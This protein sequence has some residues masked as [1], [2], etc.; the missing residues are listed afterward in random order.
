[1]TTP[2]RTPAGLTDPRSEDAGADTGGVCA[3]VAW[4]SRTNTDTA[5]RHDHQQ[6]HAG[7]DI[8][9]GRQPTPTVTTSALIAFNVER[10]S[11]TAVRIRVQRDGRVTISAHQSHARLQLTD[12]TGETRFQL[13]HDEGVVLARGKTYQLTLSLLGADQ[14]RRS[15]PTALELNITITTPHPTPGT[16]SR[17]AHSGPTTG[18]ARPT[19]TQT[20]CR[21]SDFLPA[22]TLNSWQVAALF[23][24]AVVTPDGATT[25]AYRSYKEAMEAY[26]GTPI[27]TGRIYRYLGP[28]LHELGVTSD[29]ENR[30]VERLAR[31]ARI[32]GLFPEGDVT[33]LR[34]DIAQ[35]LAR[36]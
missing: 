24:M 19:G 14:P 20:A 29:G 31:E 8:T 17:Q 18:A 15:V 9:F 13:V 26:F 21:S 7:T 35:A 32:H 12:D 2:T 11:S 1:M 10:L 30:S 33:A 16:D 25:T 5:E 3:T 28:A 22:G 27:S 36:T 23:A 34:T 4:T 6:L